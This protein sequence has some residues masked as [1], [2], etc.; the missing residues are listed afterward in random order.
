MTNVSYYSN[1]TLLL[2]NSV[3]LSRR[4]KLKQDKETRNKLLDSARTEFREKGYMKA[5]LRN[6]CKNAGLTTGALYFFFEGKED[7]FDAVTKEAVQ[8]I[9]ML[10]SS[11]YADERRMASAGLIFNFVSAKDTEDIEEAKQI[12][13][14]M[15]MHREDILLILT[16]SQGSK[17]EH[18]ADLFITQTEQHFAEMASQMQ[19]A[20][21]EKKIDKEF[22]HWLAHEMV[23]AFI[24]V[25]THI[26]NEEQAIR[27]ME[28]M[29]T[30]MV[31]GWYGLFGASGLERTR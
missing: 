2:N 11:H 5:S 1:I 18:V 28:Q 16:K 25:I 3:M 12:L 14:H 10:M 17:L 15:Y 30:Y 20:Y 26:E 7:L 22:I 8:G 27:F 24:Y 4:K 6:I 9:Q 23:N 21:P 19:T 31:A 29:V 13:H